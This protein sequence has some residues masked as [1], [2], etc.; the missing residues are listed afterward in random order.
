MRVSRVIPI[1]SKKFLDLRSEFFF[2]EYPDILGF[3][4]RLKAQLIVDPDKF[5]F[6]LPSRACNDGRPPGIPVGT[7]AES[8]ATPHRNGELERF[9]PL[10]H[11]LND[12][13]ANA[14]VGRVVAE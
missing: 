12:L 2:A 9:Q 7:D 5:D 11:P 8:V 4:L 3:R 13:L 10:L 14:V 6:Q 1:R